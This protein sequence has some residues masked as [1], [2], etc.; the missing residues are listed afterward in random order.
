[1]ILKAMLQRLYQ[2]LTR[3]PALNSR[4]HNSRQRLDAVDLADLQPGGSVAQELLP[5]LLSEKRRFEVS[6][7][8]P[9][10]VPPEYPEVEWSDEQRNAKS[11]WDRQE[12]VLR[13]LT[14]IAI[15]AKEYFNDHGEQALFVGFPVLSLP[16]GKRS[17]M[18]MRAS[19]VLAPLSFVPVDIAVR[20][21]AKHGL[22]LRATGEG[23]DLLVPNPALMTLLEQQTGKDADAL[24]ADL[25][26]DDPWEEVEA[27]MQ[28]VVDATGAATFAWTEETVP[29][30][31]PKVA[32]LPDH[33]TI[34]PSAVVGL[35]PMSNPGLMRDTKWMI[36]AEPRGDLGSPVSSFLSLRALEGESPKDAE[37]SSKTEESTGGA[38]IHETR[39]FAS[40]FFVAQA[41]PCQC[42]AVQMAESAPVLVMHGPPGTGKSQTIVNI[43]GDHLARGQRLLFVCDKRTALDVVK[44][45]LDSIGLGHLCGV[46]HDPQRD[47]RDFYMGLRAVME[48]LVD[49]RPNTDAKRKCLADVN[50]RLSA[51]H[52]ELS[53]AFHMLQDKVVTADASYHELVGAWIGESTSAAGLL[54]QKESAPGEW[55]LRLDDVEMHRA[56]VDE[57]LSRAREAGYPN[58]PWSRRVAL[59]LDQWLTLAPDA[60][61]KKWE[62]CLEPALS[63]DSYPFDPRFPLSDDLPAHAEA[64]REAAALLEAVL[65]DTLALVSDLSIRKS[66]EEVRRFRSAWEATA[67]ARALVATPLDQEL[68]LQVR[69]AWP[70]IADLNV[71]LHALAEWIQSASKWTKIFAFGRKKRARKALEPLGILGV[72]LADTTRGADFYEGLKARVVAQDAVSNSPAAPAADDD[73]SLLGYFKQVEGALRLRELLSNGLGDTGAAS[74]FSVIDSEDVGECKASVERMVTAAK[75]ADA[76]GAWI[77]RAATEGLLNAS[78][79]DE[80]SKKLRTKNASAVE[81][82]ASF[83]ASLPKLETVLRLE[84]NLAK[85]PKSMQSAVEWL[86]GVAADCS[87]AT[88]IAALKA[89]A[90]RGV[91]HQAIAEN[92]GLAHIDTARI[93]AAFDEFNKRLHE[94]QNLVRDVIVDMWAD[95]Q[96]DRL[97]AKTGSRLNSAGASLRQRLFVRGKRALKLRQMVAAGRPGAESEYP[98]TDTQQEPD[99]DPLFDLCPV[100]MVSAD[101][102]AQIFPREPLFD[103]VVFDEASQCRLEEALPVL[104]RANRVVIAGDPRQ[105]PPTRFFETALSDSEETDPETAEELHEMQ[106][107]ETEDLLGAAL[108]LDVHEAFL[109]VHYRSQNEALIGFSN[110]HFYQGRL[111]PIPGHPK[112]RGMNAPVSL[113][114]VDGIYKDQTNPDE[115]AAIVN[116]IGRLLAEPDP[117][118]IGV[119]SFNLKQ[120]T[121][122]LE[123]LEQRAANDAQFAQGLETARRR[124]GRDSFEG[125]FV[126]NLENVQGDERDLILISTTF[127]PDPEGQFRRNFG[128]LSRLGGERRLNVLVTRARSAIHVFTSIPRSEYSGAELPGP[129]ERVN[130]RHLLYAYLRYAEHLEHAYTSYNDQ[131]ETV[132]GGDQVSSEVMP[133]ESPSPL[134]TLLGKQMADVNGIS[135]TVH[136]GNDGFCIDI[137]MANPQLPEDVTLGVL[138]DFNRFRRT[139]DPIDWERFRN[140]IFRSQGWEIHRLWSPRLFRDREGEMR[141][142]L[143]RHHTLAGHGESQ[144]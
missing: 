91:L 88:A 121:L 128:A 83:T 138:T 7:D 110:N 61:C 8:V 117:P 9:L 71:R 131:L 33:P 32:S 98:N 48:E 104:L 101:T 85:L 122:I 66:D 17:D 54:D 5:A 28:H 51:L 139:P 6:A 105:L 58:N 78:A 133:S 70:T 64:L 52:R 143:E 35:F 67:S 43:I 38:T 107:S 50:A 92:P 42:A 27:V 73:V 97:L 132:R 103:A 102:V 46:I 93:D 120:R 39:D 14:E 12:R 24:L 144:D 16:P 81:L 26:F 15:D 75:R 69:G 41:D 23:A 80:A 82:L 62:A 108:N 25:E 125:L 86:T 74:V 47:R 20:R 10:F 115:A 130:G 31:I 123:R 113:V 29:V 126:K 44:Y 118:S 4:P 22:T 142:L 114:R 65:P 94:K 19:R 137:A 18:G 57:I 112:N 95:R 11:S 140:L 90:I 37:E 1:M 60:I 68:S 96:C 119:A 84:H 40:E 116:F 49:A 134:A 2:G 127:G 87:D 36:D 45:R 53:E 56:D 124:Q 21:G 106:M 30:G 79:V 129:G 109:D 77:E 55:N 3:G 76:I 63:I 136:W 100:W 111:Q 72:E 99:K 89:E 135:N 13:K 59:S 34:L 141:H